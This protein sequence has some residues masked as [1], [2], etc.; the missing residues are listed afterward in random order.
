M[1]SEGNTCL[2]PSE[3]TDPPAGLVP[4]AKRYTV[5]TLVYSRAGLIMLCFWMLWG[6]FCFN[7]MEQ[8]MPRIL[9]LQ[10]KEFGASNAA[11]AFLVGSLTGVMNM[12]ITPIV[13][14]SSDRYRSRLGRRIPFLLFP[15]PLIVLFLI[16]LG[17]SQEIG[18]AAH[19]MLGARLGFSP[20]ATILAAT[21]LLVIGFQFFNMFVASV[22]SY[23]LNDVVPAEFLGR[24]SALYSAMGQA[25]GFVFNM[26]VFRFAT[27]HTKEIYIG[28]AALYLLAFTAM[29]LFV[30]EGQYPP[31]PPRPIGGWM[32][33]LT[34]SVKTYFQECFS[35]WFYV[36]VYT[37]FALWSL[38]NSCYI[39]NVFF[40]QEIG[41]SI[42]QFGAINA[43]LNLL[44]ML[45]LYPAGW[46]SDRFHP[47]RTY[48]CSLVLTV[49]FTLVLFFW[50][51]GPAS[52]AAVL[53]IKVPVNALM[54]AT[55][56]PLLAR[57]FPRDR[58]G[59][60]ASA[61]AMVIALVVIT[62]NLMGG[63][64]I[65][66]MG[67]YRWVYIWMLVFELLSIAVM[68]AIYRSWRQLGG[69]VDYRPP[70]P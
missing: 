52:Y 50:V 30:K 62:G 68:V 27:S 5:G 47:I 70:T 42:A 38:S 14:Y 64:F 6:N 37:Q 16:F 17:F 56:F 26:F 20:M 39:F 11:I 12:I 24:L 54:T 8:V 40:A 25:A 29:C 35:H 59:Q 36:L 57:L 46:I 67:S 60:F 32:F 4:A 49:P 34:R 22:Y 41:V 61:Q 53:A 43:W 23:L 7:L 15:T 9:P 69:V 31:P 55:T 1:A 10:L 18:D 66:K 45:L 65:D 13:S 2:E 44:T 28:S 51:S 63:W 3:K 21:S 48:F 33:R 58:F 19:S